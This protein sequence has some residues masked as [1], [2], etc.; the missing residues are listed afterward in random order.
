LSGNIYVVD[1]KN[2]RVQKYAPDGSFIAKFG[3]GMLNAPKG[4][5]VDSYDNVWVADSGNHRIVQFNPLGD[6]LEEFRSEVYIIDPQKIAVKNGKIYIADASSGRKRTEAQLKE[7]LGKLDEYL[8]KVEASDKKEDG[9]YGSDARG[10]ELPPEIVKA[11]QR[12]E[13]LEKALAL[14]NNYTPAL[15]DLGLCLAYQ[16]SVDK[17]LESLI[18]AQGLNRGDPMTHY[19]LGIVYRKAGSD[20]EA[21][22]AYLEALSILFPGE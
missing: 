22:R 9:Q 8:V 7:E 20:G 11:Q 4:I 21:V 16:D 17:A 15:I 1:T 14:D 19:Y 3:E 6:F 5:D 10:D 12:R 2:D 13:K 18:Q